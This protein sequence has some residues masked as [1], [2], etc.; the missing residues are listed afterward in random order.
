MAP[1][2]QSRV[3]EDFLMKKV[4]KGDS[5]ACRELVERYHSKVVH[6]IQ[7]A[8]RCDAQRA[9]DLAQNTWIQVVRSART[10]DPRGQFSSWVF[11]IAKNLS[12]NE[13]RSQGVRKEQELFEDVAP[14]ED[15]V[16]PKSAEELHLARADSQSL[17]NAIAKLPDQ[18]RI[19][20]LS[21]YIEEQDHSIIAQS[22]GM[23]EN[24]LSAL[25]YRAKKNLKR[26]LE[27]AS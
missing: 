19:A 24:A 15:S 2:D 3:H 1:S 27:E 17:M 12:L 6:F 23:T 18:Q 20:I 11:R 16:A 7:H 14:A 13:M 26:H 5:D 21:W 4:A 8:L 22:L 9:E 10:Y 25:L